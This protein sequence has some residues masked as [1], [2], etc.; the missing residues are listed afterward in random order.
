MKKNLILLSS[1][2]ALMCGFSSCEDNDSNEEKNRQDNQQTDSIGKAFATMIY[3]EFAV[4]TIRIKGNSFIGSETVPVNVYFYGKND[5]FVVSPKT[6]VLSENEIIAVIP[7]DIANSKPIRITNSVVTDVNEA[8][9]SKFLFR[10]DRNILVDFESNMLYMNGDTTGVTFEKMELGK[11]GKYGVI[12]DKSWDANSFLSFQ[13]Y[14]DA[15]SEKTVFGDFAK[16]IKNGNLNIND[17]CIKFEIN[18]P[19]DKA[20][21]LDIMTFGFTNGDEATLGTYRKFAAFFNP[22]IPVIDTKPVSSWD[23]QE[24]EP[25]D[26]Q[27][28]TSVC[29]KRF[30]THGWMTVTIPLSEVFF[31]ASNLAYGSS[32]ENVSKGDFSNG[33]DYKILGD[34]ANSKSFVSKRTYPEV[35]TDPEDTE[36]YGG[37]I[38]G[39]SP[40][41]GGD[42]SHNDFAIGFD[43]IRIVPNDGNGAIYPA[44]KYGVPERH[45][46]DAP[47]LK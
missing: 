11:N 13:P 7:N 3:N 6:M 15:P 14:M 8:L 16:E 2:L 47:I 21:K 31:S 25:K 18:V 10:D 36:A 42:E 37:F 29:K 30:Y 39:V 45:Y 32:Y 38:I 1:V 9:D 22:C 43:N 46:Y 4:D 44:L 24:T 23:E 17:F 28:M 41:D 19:E 20:M 12:A 35:Y 40:N 5:S 26:I 34:P 33:D 27:Y